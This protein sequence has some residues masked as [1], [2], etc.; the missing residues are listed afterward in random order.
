MVVVVGEVMFDEI[1]G[2]KAEQRLS[3]D[4]STLQ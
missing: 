1:F 3:M 2:E 4:I